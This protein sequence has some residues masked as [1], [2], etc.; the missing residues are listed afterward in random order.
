MNARNP[1]VSSRNLFLVVG[2]LMVVVVAAA[3]IAALTSH[4]AFAQQSPTCQE[5][6]CNAGKGDGPEPG[7][8]A[9]GS[10]AGGDPGNSGDHNNSPEG[11]YPGDTATLQG[12]PQKT[13]TDPA[14]NKAAPKGDRAAQKRGPK[15]VE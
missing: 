10:D 4:S 1:L 5:Y 6:H 12:G 2:A 14:V 11:P 9:R 3:T 13:R 7:D 8:T 15:S